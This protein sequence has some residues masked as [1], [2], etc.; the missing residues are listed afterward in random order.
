MSDNQTMDNYKLKVFLYK[1]TPVFT[2]V[3]VPTP[4]VSSGFPFVEK[5]SVE[6][7]ESKYFSKY[8]LTDYVSSYT[9]SQEL[10]ENTFSWSMVLMN[11]FLSFNEINVNLLVEGPR[12]GPNSLTNLAQY[13]A[14]SN[15]IATSTN[16]IVQAKIGR[17][18]TVDSM[19]V[20]AGAITTPKTGLK[21]E[22]LIQPYDVV[23]VFLYRGK[24][25]ITELTGFR[26]K[27]SSQNGRIIFNVDAAGTYTLTNGDMR[28][29]SVLLSPD[30]ID[31]SRTLFSNE[32][33]GFV[34][35]KTATDDVGTVETINISGNGISRLFGATRRII[36]QG[37]L[38]SSLYDIVLS[39]NPNDFS[40]FTTTFANKTIV[41]I[42]Q[43]F[44]SSIYGIR[45]AVSR[46]TVIQDTEDGLAGALVFETVNPESSFYDISSIMVR[47]NL[48]TNLFTIP[49]FLLGLVM[50]RHGFQYRQPNDPTALQTLTTQVTAAAT[51]PT[52]LTSQFHFDPATNQIVTNQVEKTGSIASLDQNVVDSVVNSNQSIQAENGYRFPIFYSSEL[53]NLRGFFLFFA[54][55]L[56]TY[57][58]DL[59]TPFEIIDDIKEKTFIEFFERPNGEFYIRAPQYND[60]TTTIMSST[61]DVVN[62]N[63]TET[64][65]NLVTLQKVAY[66]SDIINTV[67]SDAF[68]SFTDGKL[69]LQYGFIEAS[70]D[71]NPNASGTKTVI[72]A[73]TKTRIPGLAKY[74]EYLLRLHNASLKSGSLVVGYDQRLVVGKTFFDEK[75][76]KFGYITGVSK[77]VSTGG[78]STITI[79]LSY[80]RDAYQNSEALVF[81]HIDTLVD[82]A[83]Q[84]QEAEIVDVSNPESPDDIP[85]T[86]A[87]PLP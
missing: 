70:A 24:V 29:E 58:P 66:V 12:L 16:T 40:A 68:F 44:F 21:L 63:Y 36:K 69:F 15:D 10:E 28:I 43:D 30:P 62:R 56:K 54:E 11:K 22:D 57:A 61:V 76:N 78:N 86:P 2:R 1:Y 33:N 48:T 46:E 65:T 81:E 71:A 4:P 6:L 55:I 32:F 50:K 26:Q 87:N 5:F 37:V 74:A 79:T 51:N 80:V 18:T 3:G 39:T 47:N 59:K 14:S 17:G 20:Q 19:T 27:V 77:A 42:F 72:D 52:I 41:N 35:I 23:S 7:N 9:F 85:F 60:T 82:L 38:Q 84:F 67:L 83:Q 49:P 53:N 31:P 73:F 34:M 64:L 45:F 75:H 13:E 25:P 8:D